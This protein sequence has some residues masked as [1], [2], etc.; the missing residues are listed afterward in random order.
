MMT[1][2]IV[3]VV[4]DVVMMMM[5]TMVIVMITMIHKAICDADVCCYVLVSWCLCWVKCRQ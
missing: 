3:M 5:L 2:V 1:M 4:M